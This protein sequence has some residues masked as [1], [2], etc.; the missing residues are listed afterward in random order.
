[1]KEETKSFI[2]Q[3]T[4]K[5]ILED[6]AKQKMYIID[7]CALIHHPELL[8]YFSEDE[9]VRI[10]TKVIDELGK[11]KDMRSKKYSPEL[12]KT[13][14]RL[15]YEIERKYLKLF[16]QYNKMRFMI[17]NAEL[18]LLPVELDKNVLDN[19]ILSVA[20]KYLEWD[21]VIISDDGVFRLTSLAQKIK[22]ITSE[23]FIK[24]HEV[25]KKS[26]EN[27]IERFEKAGGLLDL[28]SNVEII[29]SQTSEQ[30]EIGQSNNIAAVINL[31]ESNLGD[32]A[33]N[34]LPIRELKKVLSADLNEQ[35]FALLQN[36]GI[37]TIGQ[38]KELTPKDVAGLKAKG[39][40]IILKNNIVRAIN[41]FG[42]ML[43][44]SNT[45]DGEV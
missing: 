27:W 18:D 43:N 12:S 40:Q 38:F 39:K 15:A 5:G 8:L 45:I 30:S 44:E 26:L 36:N 34:G 23:D 9:F 2:S 3:K 13:A 6:N 33:V 7:T 37:K 24:Q 20:L 35:A 22:A 11:I 32:I 28:Q 16:N 21:T 29:K 1:M 31:E 41:K 17:E 19:Q 42:I 4:K 14:K 25:Y 10:P